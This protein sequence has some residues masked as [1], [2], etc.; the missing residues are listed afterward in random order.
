MRVLTIDRYY[1]NFL[2]DLYRR[3]ERPRGSYAEQWRAVM[4]T[5]FG[6]SDAYSKNLAALGHEGTEIVANCLALQRRWAQEHDRVPLPLRFLPESG[7]YP[8]GVGRWSEEIVMAQVRAYKPDVVHVQDP[9]GIS[10]RLF[11]ELKA[12]ARFVTAQIASYFPFIEP[13]KKFDLV[14]S[15]LPNYVEQFR[16]H[17]IRAGYLGLGFDATILDRVERTDIHPVVFVGGVSG[18]HPIRNRLLERVAAEVPLEWWGYGADTLP[19]SS[20]L[21]SRY[22]GQAWGVDAYRALASGRI[23]I[24][25]HEAIAGDYANNMRLYEATG[26]GTLLITDE[27]RNL[28]DLFMPGIEVVVYRSDDELIEQVRHYMMHEQEARAIA[29]AGQRRTLATHT[30]RHRM[31]RFVELVN[32]LA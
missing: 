11:R 3:E 10:P 31:Q 28:A 19:P 20:A 6:T 15:S 5:C 21:R 24:N 16:A 30:Y 18:A 1:D 7:A 27:K 17:G 26:V 25:R 22:R 8:R 14:L 4:D 29:A 12:V 2:D 9:L 13:L 23:C 32:A